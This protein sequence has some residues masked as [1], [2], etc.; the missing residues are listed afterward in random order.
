MVK[1]IR[2]SAT[3]ARVVEKIPAVDPAKL[4]LFTLLSFVLVAFTIEFDNEAERRIP[5]WTTNARRDG[6]ARN[7]VWLTSLA[8]YLNCMKF[9][10]ADG[11]RVGDLETL[12]RTKA[13]LPGMLRW[14]Y[15]TI[16]PD[17]SDKRAKIPAADHVVRATRMGAKA[18]EVWTPL[19][20]EIEQRWS[21][22]FG[23]AAVTDLRA[24]LIDVAAQIS[25]DLP[26][27][28]PILGYGL[29]NSRV[30][31]PRAHGAPTPPTKLPLVSLVARVLLAFALEFEERSRGSLAI[32]ANV[33][34]VITPDGVAP[35]DIPTLSGVSKESIAMALKL[36][37][38]YKVTEDVCDAANPKNKLVRLT[39]KGVE[40]KAR[41]E[42]LI[43]TLEGE[44]ANK[45]GAPKI[46]RL[47]A[48]LET[49]VRAEAEILGG[50]QPSAQNWRFNEKPPR[51][52]PHFP[53][54]LH[55]G[56]YPDGS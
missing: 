53:M 44:W 52:L 50:V 42:K 27:C 11:V 5:N 56:G 20:A 17:P 33:L 32:G 10:G 49:I 15:V 21:Q 24:A 40:V 29:V 12:A 16:A 31:K 26:E 48:A 13:N 22:R 2:A 1:Q 35:R 18:I 28:M 8:M 3:P 9:V 43:A 34:R 14:G 4:P 54:V 6:G 36:L 46:Q 39:T 55:R 19:F 23:A 45:F 41:Y 37:Q 47:L 38:N 25:E 30:E 7:G 51:T